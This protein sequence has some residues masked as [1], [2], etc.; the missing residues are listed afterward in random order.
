M[1][2]ASS[3]ASILGPVK[4]STEKLGEAEFGAAPFGRI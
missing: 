2:V 4:I 1:A 3:H